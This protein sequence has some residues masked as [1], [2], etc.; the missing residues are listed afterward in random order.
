MMERTLVLLKPCT[1]QRG[2]VGEIISIF[3][4]KGLHLCGMKMMQLDDAIL[5]EHYAHLAQRPFFQR[6]K[7]SMEAAPII[8]MCLEGV[9]AVTVVHALAGPTNGRNAPAG[10][11][12]GNYCMSCQENIVHTSDSHETAVIEIKRFSGLRSCMIGNRLR[13]TIYMPT[14][15]IKPGDREGDYILFL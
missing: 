6:V 13:S 5:N 7:S 8:A 4:K 14:M 2:L 9:E 11:I 1:L 3:E 12:R 10:T 15:N